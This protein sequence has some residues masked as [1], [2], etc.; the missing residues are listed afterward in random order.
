MDF[1]SYTTPDS[2]ELLRSAQTRYDED[3]RARTVLIT[4]A[5]R[6][7]LEMGLGGRVGLH[8]LPQA[9]GFYTH[10]CRMTR[11]GTDPHY[12]DLTYFEYTG[13]QATDWLAAIGEAP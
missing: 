2:V 10:R 12:Y 9:E 5:V 11:V 13:Q 1:D 3:K 8:S 6:L 7:S 4:E